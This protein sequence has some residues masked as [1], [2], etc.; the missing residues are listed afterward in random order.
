MNVRNRTHFYINN[1]NSWS[2][3]GF[4]DNLSKKYENNYTYFIQIFYKKNL[5]V[6]LIEEELLND[7]Y[8]TVIKIP[9][10]IVFKYFEVPNQNI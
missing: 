10:N 9:R 8:K 1:I 7:P 6:Y 3:H 4:I 5:L 2:W